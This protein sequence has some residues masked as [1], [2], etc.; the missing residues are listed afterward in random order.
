MRS[1][2]TPHTNLVIICNKLG[3]LHPPHPSQN[4]YTPWPPLPKSNYVILE[5]PPYTDFLKTKPSLLK[6]HKSVLKHIIRFPFLLSQTEIS[7]TNTLNRIHEFVSFFWVLLYFFRTYISCSFGPL[8]IKFCSFSPVS[9][10]NSG[11]LNKCSLF[12]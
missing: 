5:H 8:T 6:L 3:A 10:F 4:G 2:E 11:Q 9:S 7:W 12:I 1:F